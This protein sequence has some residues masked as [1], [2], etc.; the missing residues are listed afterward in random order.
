MSADDLRAGSGANH[1]QRATT[2]RRGKQDP[3]SDL[4]EAERRTFAISSVTSL[5]NEARSYDDLTL[6]TRVLACV[7]DALWEVDAVTARSL[8]RK[9]WD[10]AEEAD[11]QEPKAKTKD[12][13]PAM[14]LALGRI[15]GRDLRMEVLGLAGKRD[16]ALSEEFLAKLKDDGPCRLAAEEFQDRLVELVRFFEIEEVSATSDHDCG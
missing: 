5:A 16:R 14:V 9:A 6:R 10:A 15:S 1:Q 2:S 13:P 7:A 3:Q 11:A 12:N 8:F 4:V